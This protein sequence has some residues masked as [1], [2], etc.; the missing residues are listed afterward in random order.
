MT[1][2]DPDDDPDPDLAAELATN[3]SLKVGLP[4]LRRIA[5]ALR[6]RPVCFDGKPNPRPASA[7]SIIDDRRQSRL[8]ADDRGVSAILVWS[9]LVST[10]DAS[11]RFDGLAGT[12]GEAGTGGSDGVVERLEDGRRVVEGV[13]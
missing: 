4:S 3:G 7:S 11:R 5:V 6:L 2:L 1:V 10:K 9:G 13:R 8:G 12:R